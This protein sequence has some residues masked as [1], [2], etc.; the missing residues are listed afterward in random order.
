[1]SRD[2]WTW[3]PEPGAETEV[4]RLKPEGPAC[5]E[6]FYGPLGV[7]KWKEKWWNPSAGLPQQPQRQAVI[8]AHIAELVASGQPK[9]RDAFC[10]GNQ[11][12]VRCS[13]LILA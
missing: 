2:P 11:I 1:M 6:E 3:A 13:L 5:Y 9:D 10:P 12:P 4:A 7:Q 8:Q